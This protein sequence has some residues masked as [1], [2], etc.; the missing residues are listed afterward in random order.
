MCTLCFTIYCRPKCTIVSTLTWA[1]C[2]DWT[3]RIPC[4]G[5]TCSTTSTCTYERTSSRSTRPPPL[6][7]C[8]ALPISWHTT[9]L[10]KNDFCWKTA[11][12]KSCSSFSFSKVKISIF[13]SFKSEFWVLKVEILV[14]QIN[15]LV[16]L[17]QNSGFWLFRSKFWFKSQTFSVHR[18]K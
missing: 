12:P 8:L 13:R 17:T 14:L 6:W 1:K 7:T 15:I 4:A 5:V 3:K 10:L 2:T 9:G 16:F 18:S 11:S